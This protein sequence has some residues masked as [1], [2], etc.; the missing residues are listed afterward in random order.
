MSLKRIVTAVILSCL[1]FTTSALFCSAQDMTKQERLKNTLY[2]QGNNYACA[3]DGYLTVIDSEDKTVTP[4]I[5][6]G[7]FYVPLRFVLESFGV[8]VSWDDEAKSVVATGGK[9]SLY[10]SVTQDNVTLGQVSVK[11]DYD[12]Y[13]DNERTFLALDDVSKI[14]KCSTYRYE[15]N[16]SAVIAVGEEWNSERDAEKQAH[17]AMEFAI[18]PFFKMFT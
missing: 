12:C 8:Q 15:V 1:L 9:K 17:S 5:V 2:L 14:I 7:V 11:F 18:S 10:V 6:D 13:I 3:K 4:K 16:K